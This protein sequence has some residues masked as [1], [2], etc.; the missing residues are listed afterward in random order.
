[1]LVIRAVHRNAAVGGQGLADHLAVLLLLENPVV[2][3]LCGRPGVVPAFHHH[4]GAVVPA[5]SDACLHDDALEQGLLVVQVTRIQAYGI[6]RLEA[7]RIALI[8]SL[9]I[10][11]PGVEAQGG[12]A[13]PVQFEA[14]A[15]RDKLE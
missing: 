11:V 12:L 7:V 13:D 1:M 2:P 9:R 14:Y 6:A 5:D 15:C 4:H 10:H 8:E 3:S